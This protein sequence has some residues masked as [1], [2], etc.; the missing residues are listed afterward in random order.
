[1]NEYLTKCFFQR[2]FFF[3]FESICYK[4][5]YPALHMFIFKGNDFKVSLSF[6]VDAYFTPNVDFI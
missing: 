4:D 5:F 2:S 6:L 1:M 3:F